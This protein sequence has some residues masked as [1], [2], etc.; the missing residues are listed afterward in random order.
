MGLTARALGGTGTQETG[1]KPRA[2]FVPLVE[3]KIGRVVRRNSALAA[4]VRVLTTRESYETNGPWGSGGVDM[5]R[6]K[7]NSNLH[8]LKLER[9]SLSLFARP[10]GSELRTPCL[11]Q[12]ATR[13]KT[14]PAPTLH[15]PCAFD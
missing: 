4:P 11:G 3:Q 8:M 9:S 14:P 7:K 10:R 15:L 1:P 13:L 6:Y 5:R 12:Q 2:R